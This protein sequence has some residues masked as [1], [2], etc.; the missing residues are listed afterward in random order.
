MRD[1]KKGFILSVDLDKLTEGNTKNDILSKIFT[2]AKN[3]FDL[4]DD[5]EKID[6]NEVTSGKL[7]EVDQCRKK[8]IDVVY[9]ICEYLYEKF[10]WMNELNNNRNEENTIKTDEYIAVALNDICAKTKEVYV[11]VLNCYRRINCLGVDLFQMSENYDGNDVMVLEEEEDEYETSD[12]VDED[13]YEI[14][15]WEWLAPGEELDEDTVR[16]CFGCYGLNYDDSELTKK[17]RGTYYIFI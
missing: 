11:S 2:T 14:S 4:S 17:F 13:G 5:L 1:A 8:T 16:E 9:K 15:S 7:R 12:Y 6:R 3:S 10:N